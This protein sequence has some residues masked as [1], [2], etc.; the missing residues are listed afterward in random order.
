MMIRKLIF[1]EDR[2]RVLNITFKAGILIG[3]V[4]L[5]MAVRLL[6]T[7]WG[8]YLDEYDPYL[9][10]K[11]AKFIVENG[12]AAWYEWYDKG[13]WYPWGI[14]MPKYD[15]PG[16]GFLEALIYMFLSGLGLH[17]TLLEVAVLLPVATSVIAVLAMYLIGRE[18]Y[19]DVAGFLAATF[20]ALSPTIIVRTA[21]GF[22]D[23]ESLGLPFFLLSLYFFIRSVNRGSAS[24]A[25]LSGIFLGLMS[26]SWGAYVFP[27]N[28]YGAIMLAAILTNR[29]NRVLARNFILTISIALVIA[30]QVPLLGPKIV[31]SSRLALALLAILAIVLY[32]IISAFV[33]EE[34][35][36]LY[37]SI[38]LAAAVAIGIYVY[39]ATGGI[40]G[41][42]LAV[43][44]PFAAS[45]LPIFPTVGEHHPSSWGA[46]YRETRYLLVFAI[47]G[48]IL[49]MRRM[50]LVDLT[51]IVLGAVSVYVGS[52]M[53]RLTVFADIATAL[54]ASI[55]LA[56]LLSRASRQIKEGVVKV[57]RKVI[58]T[59]W[60][61]LAVILLIIAITTPIAY[62]G[63]IAADRPAAIASSAGGYSKVV[64]D[65]MVALAWMRD[66]LPEDAVVGAWWDYGY[67][68]NVMA[69]KSTLADNGTMNGTQIKLIA[70]ALLSD[71]ETAIGIFKQ[72]GVTHFVVFEPWRTVAGVHIPTRMLGEVGKS[73]AM[74]HIAGFE[75][76]DY[77]ALIHGIWWPIGPKARN[78]TLYRLLYYPFRQE[79]LS[80]FNIDMPPPEHFK[81]IY[82]SPQKWVLVYEVLY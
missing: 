74:M 5:A 58:T 20:F 28:I 21:A 75:V 16:V 53:I 19:G 8:I 27:F 79:Y 49:L 10:F 73:T 70:I 36:R 56:Y 66:N 60:Q 72:L 40:G 22:T 45:A 52:V 3:I 4:A 13:Q 7:K 71:E 50:R 14:Y 26:A 33:R 64:S 61:G 42:L 17:V 34:K 65:W 37:T 2:T 67:W 31:V 11:N 82:A 63:V 32:E 15:Y 23:T 54:L 24:S 81:L 57:K 59:R 47:A 55:T 30:S 6:P 77:L 44:N 41:R 76:S 18:V 68:L 48:I 51:L 43:I 9:H 38:A 62:N 46:L 80:N 12:F 69:N 39:W 1:I 29:Y 35:V 78:T 25:I